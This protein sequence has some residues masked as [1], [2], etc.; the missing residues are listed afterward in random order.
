MSVSSKTIL[1]IHGLFLNSK[2]WAEWREYFSSMGYNCHSPS[3]PFHEGIPEELRKDP[4]PRLTRVTFTDVY[5][6]YASYISTLSEKPIV[7][8]HSVGGLVSQK[9][10]NNDLA[11][12]AV[13]LGSA[14][15]FGIVSFSMD[16]LMS[17][18]PI[19]NIFKGNTLS[20][21]DVN[22]FHTTVCN[23]VDRKTAERLWHDYLVPESR[24]I[25]RTSYFQGRIDFKRPHGPLLIIAGEID[26]SAPPSFCRNNFL[27]YEDRAGITDYKEFKGR[28]HLMMLEEDWKEVADYIAE[29]V[30]KSVMHQAA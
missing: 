14:P 15:P 6:N 29:W 17:H 23:S 30:N 9:L 2:V 25:H 10:L 13:T 7:I 3:Y 21:P 22:F 1:F 8:G 20:T 18:L 4:D 24:N 12:A 11:A 19:M 16:F 26:H 5:D 28:S 27:A